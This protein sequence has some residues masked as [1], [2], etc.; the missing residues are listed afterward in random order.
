[1]K[2]NQIAMA[3]CVAGT[4]VGTMASAGYK[5]VSTL[6]VDPVNRSA[7]GSLAGHR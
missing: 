1:M 4:L 7:R 2:K 3:L 6:T 5:Y